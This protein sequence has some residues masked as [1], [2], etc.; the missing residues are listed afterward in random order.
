MDY[1]N[2]GMYIAMFGVGYLIGKERAGLYYDKRAKALGDEVDHYK[3]LY[4]KH[5]GVPEIPK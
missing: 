5:A 2:F 4:H 3:R 1:L